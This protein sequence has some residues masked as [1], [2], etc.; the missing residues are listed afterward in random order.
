MEARRSLVGRGSTRSFSARPIAKCSLIQPRVWCPATDASIRRSP[1]YD[2]LV[3]FRGRATGNIIVTVRLRGVEQAFCTD[4]TGG[5][6]A[7]ANL[8]DPSPSFVAVS[9][10]EVEIL[11]SLVPAMV[12]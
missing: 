6:M 9:Q 4:Q 3:R 5:S 2:Y 1:G 11:N 10:Q 12:R 8:T 7:F